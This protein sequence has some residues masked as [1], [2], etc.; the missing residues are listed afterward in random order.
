MDMNVIEK[1][2]KKTYGCNE[3]INLSMAA[4]FIPFI[5]TFFSPILLYCTDINFSPV[6]LYVFYFLSF[7]LLSFVCYAFLLFCFSAH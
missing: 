7:L 4:P 3:L 6:N 1:N 2:E 5:S